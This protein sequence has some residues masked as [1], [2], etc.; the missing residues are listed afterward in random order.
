MSTRAV[1]A[2][3]DDSFVACACAAFFPKA[4]GLYT[5]GAWGGAVAPSLAERL[6]RF[7]PDK[8]HAYAEP[9]LPV[10]VYLDLW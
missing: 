4:P 5:T 2:K 9:T 3:P 10:A 6:S 7:L 1:F 8:A